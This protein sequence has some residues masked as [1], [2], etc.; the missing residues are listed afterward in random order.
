MKILYYF[1]YDANKRKAVDRQPRKHYTDGHRPKHKHYI[2]WYFTLR[3][4][5]WRSLVLHKGA[6]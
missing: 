1:Y 3:N 4:I 2:P 6:L 5:P